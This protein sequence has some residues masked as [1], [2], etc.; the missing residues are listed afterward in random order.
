MAPL[1]RA[2]QQAAAAEPELAEVWQQLLDRR[3]R[4]WGVW[5]ACGHGC[6][7]RARVA[8]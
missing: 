1:Y 5:S 2:V 6:G 8:K 7:L 4:N 3:A